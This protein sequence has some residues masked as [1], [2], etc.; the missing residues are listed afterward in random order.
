[1]E[2]ILNY[3]EKS[4]D[5]IFVIF[6]ILGIILLIVSIIKGGVNIGKLKIPK[7]KTPQSVM[8]SVLSFMMIVIPS[9]MLINKYHNNHNP[10]ALDDYKNCNINEKICIDVLDND[11][12]SDSDN[13]IVSVIG[14]PENGNISL[15]EKKIE[16][17]TTKCCKDTVVYQIIDGR[18]GCDTAKV[19]ITVNPV[20]Q[21]VKGK[22]TDIY[23]KCLSGKYK[24]DIC[25][26]IYNDM[27]KC[28]IADNEGVFEI[29]T[30][31]ENSSCQIS[32][33]EKHIDMFWTKNKKLQTLLYNPID[34]VQITFCKGY[35]RQN[36]KPIG[37]YANKF[38]IKF[39]DMEEIIADGDVSSNTKY[40][41]LYCEL[42]LFGTNKSEYSRKNR[43][44]VLQCK[45]V[46]KGEDGFEY[47]PISINVG[48]SSKGWRTNLNKKL[49]KGYYELQLLTKTGDVLEY[50]EFEIK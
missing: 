30:D 16:Y 40:R 13:L 27:S 44:R 37:V 8:L 14:Y 25:N 33:N 41:R 29:K 38:N 3:L 20:Y 35:D 47:N 49:L 4:P 19:Y 34:S 42:K 2:H 22:I 9:Y 5:S 17:T 45:F 31:K 23:G 26:M 15:A 50:F 48:T 11:F 21:T 46:S 32:I 18:G 36:K 12:D 6:I 24:T 39:T 10:V 7:L 1:M 43:K 28:I